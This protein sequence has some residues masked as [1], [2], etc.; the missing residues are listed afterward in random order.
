MF[1]ARLSTGRAGLAGIPR[2]G[3]DDP[4]HFPQRS[5]RGSRR[6]FGQ[7]TYSCP[8]A[9]L[10][11]LKPDHVPLGVGYY[12]VA[13]AARLLRIPGRNIRRW[14]GGYSHVASGERITIPPL[15]VPQLPNFENQIELGFRDLI[16]LR[17]VKSFLEAGIGLN[18]IRQ[19]LEYAREC[20]K[21]D[22]PFSTRR[23]RTDGKTIFL[24]TPCS[25][26]D[27]ELLDLKKKQYALKPVIERTFK[28]LD[29]EEDTV[30]RWRPF[31]GKETIVID[32]KRSFGQPI[33]A[34]SGVPTIALADAVLA[35]GSEKIVAQQYD[36]SEAVVHDAFR[37][38]ES[39]K[40]A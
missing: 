19:C 9:R 40:A 12:T 28:D 16:E 1:G 7:R 24:D 23:F 22:H 21:D 30:A 3:K 13:E 15:W 33:A 29:L 39:L 10:G 25:A 35:E 11:F 26:G 18:A 17:F 4:P 20:V 14:L 31:N 36:V 5:T 27:F 8:M 37:F 2:G 6:F 32:P 34:S 38:E